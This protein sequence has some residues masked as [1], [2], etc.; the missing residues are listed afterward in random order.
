MSL[1]LMSLVRMP[2]FRLPFVSTPSA[3][4]RMPP[5]GRQRNVALLPA[6]LALAVSALASPVLAQDET[7]YR[8]A[9]GAVIEARVLPAAGCAPLAVVSH[10]FGGT[11]RGNRQLAEALQQAGYRVVVPNHAETGPKVLFQLVGTGGGRERLFDMVADPRLLGPRL[12]DVGAILAA[13]KRRCAVPFTVL[14]G[15]SM[16]ARTALLEAGAAN[17]A[18]LKGQNRFD[19]YIAISPAGENTKLF[20][21]GA[22]A[23]LRKPVF[24]ITGTR[25]DGEGVG[26]ALRL[27][28]FEGLPAGFKR[29]AV[30]D[31]ATHS[32]LSGRGDPRT[33]QLV[34]AMA[35]EFLAMVRSGS[36]RAA[37]PRPGVFLSDK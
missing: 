13:E 15:H 9:D 27:S 1:V 23:G 2:L 31:D 7:T 28:A 37:T 21:R 6:W 30:I 16:G 12:E 29:L 3:A 26:Y 24:L 36:A 4:Q 34:G 18:G 17:N 11:A 35:V 25:D 20:P 22:M 33:G 10:G 14:A 8:R 19:A 5:V 32:A